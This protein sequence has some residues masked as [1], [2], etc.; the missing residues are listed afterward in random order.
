M[1]AIVISVMGYI[2]SS[3]HCWE[4]SRWALTAAAALDG[5][6]TLNQLKFEVLEGLVEGL[7]EGVEDASPPTSGKCNVIYVGS[8]VTEDQKTQLQ[9]Y[10]RRFKVR[11]VYF[12]AAE[13]ANDPEVN[14]RLGISQDFTEPLV[15]APFISLASK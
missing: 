4:L 7:E 6:V 8:T 13:T 15:S 1:R 10:S 11:I 3:H 14:S 5:S 12:N 2:H 9:T